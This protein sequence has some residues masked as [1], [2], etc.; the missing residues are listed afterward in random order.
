MAL[1]TFGIGALGGWAW[2]VFIIIGCWFGFCELYALMAAKQLRPSRLIVVGV[3]SLMLWVAAI[4]KT[5]YFASIIA[6][7]AMAAFFRMLFRKPR[8]ST[9]DIGATLLAMFYVAYMPAHFILLRDIGAGVPGRLPWQEPGFG[10]LV[11]TLLVIA[12]SDIGAYFAGKLFGRHLLSPDISPKKTQEGSLAGGFIGVLTGVALGPFT[13]LPW[14]HTVI[15]STLLVVV[16]QL[17][18]LSESLLKRD[19]GMKNTG[20][21]L[22]GHGGLLDRADSYIFA[23]VVAFYYIHWVLFK[24]GLAQDV[25]DWMNQGF[26]TRLLSLGDYLP[27]Y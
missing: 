19:A 15:L 5:Q 25:L 20:N 3:G 8:A 16:G 26:F 24:E 9:G 10:Y 14:P 12:M 2:Q 13:G 11:Y 1:V 23:G 27:L 6:A 4:H 18:D 17:G 21:W 7:G 22:A